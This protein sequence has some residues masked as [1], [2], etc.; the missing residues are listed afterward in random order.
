MI[1]ARKSQSNTN[2][3]QNRIVKLPATCKF[4]Y[5]TKLLFRAVSS[6]PP[7][8]TLDISPR[9]HTAKDFAGNVLHANKCTEDGWRGRRSFLATVYLAL[10]MHH[11]LPGGG[12]EVV[13]STSGMRVNN[14]DWKSE[15]GWSRRGQP[16]REGA[17]MKRP[18]DLVEWDDRLS[19]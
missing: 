15:R 10:P 6:E 2:S 3:Q 14:E 13:C 9:K 12:S 11:P 19:V 4:C 8:D 16:R 17:L 18:G 5:P 1:H 7:L